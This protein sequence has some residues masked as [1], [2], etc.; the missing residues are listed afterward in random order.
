MLPKNNPFVGRGGHKG[1][2]R[3]IR[4]FH[5]DTGS[6]AVVGNEEPQV[7]TSKKTGQSPRGFCP[8]AQRI[9]GFS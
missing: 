4:G 1:R 3:G 8:A 7:G 5:S 6:E 9:H 2:P